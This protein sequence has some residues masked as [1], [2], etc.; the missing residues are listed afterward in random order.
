MRGLKVGW[1]GDEV[2]Y[3]MDRRSQGLPSRAKSKEPNHGMIVREGK[4]LLHL[5]SSPPHFE[6]DPHALVSATVGVGHS[7]DCFRHNSGW[8]TFSAQSAPGS[9][10]PSRK[11]SNLRRTGLRCARLSMLWVLVT[12]LICACWSVEMDKG[13]TYV[14]S[15]FKKNQS[16]HWHQLMEPWQAGERPA[17][18]RL[19]PWTGEDGHGAELGNRRVFEMRRVQIHPTCR[20]QG[21]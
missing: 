13:L 2:Q 15:M 1:L 12:S 20:G 6:G 3:S 16:W 4:I 7:L 5:F 8:K 11:T 9:Q 19:S 18:A 17:P 10:V 14:L 21:A